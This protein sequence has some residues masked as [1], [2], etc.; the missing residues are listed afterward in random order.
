[1]CPG[2]HRTKTLEPP[3][4]NIYRSVSALAEHSQHDFT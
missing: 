1:M 3:L 2:A 4:L